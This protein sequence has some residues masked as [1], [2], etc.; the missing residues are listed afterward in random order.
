M[1]RSSLRE[2]GREVG[3][4]DASCVWRLW[5][6]T[7]HLRTPWRGTDELLDVID[8]SSWAKDQ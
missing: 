4:G 8:Q 7:L 5:G 3:P 1:K 6:M 2:T